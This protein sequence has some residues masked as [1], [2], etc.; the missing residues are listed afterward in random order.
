MTILDAF[1]GSKKVKRSTISKA[2]A[3]LRGAGA[4]Y[5]EKGDVT[6]AKE[7]VQKIKENMEKLQNRLEDDI[8][9]LEDKFDIDLVRIEEFFI[10]SKKSDI[11]NV[12]LA[13]L[14]EER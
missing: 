11:T 3:T 9:E 1:L 12:K 10:K 4:I 2:G 14:W 13:L 6:R 5:G 8:L 7:A